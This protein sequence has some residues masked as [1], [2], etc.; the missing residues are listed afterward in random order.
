M[1]HPYEGVLKCHRFDSL[2][3]SFSMSHKKRLNSSAKMFSQICVPTAVFVLVSSGK[4]NLGVLEG[5][6]GE[7]I[8]PHCHG[9]PNCYSH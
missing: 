7:Y 1:E 9:P 2:L 4:E 5:K 8:F 3:D 6:E